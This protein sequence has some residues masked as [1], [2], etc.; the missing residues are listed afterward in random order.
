M[1]KE[2]LPS[3]ECFTTEIETWKVKWQE[4]STNYG[5]ASLP[6][7]PRGTLPQTSEMYPSIKVLLTI[8]ATLPV[9]TCSA[10]RSFSSLKRTKTS[11]RSSMTT[12]RLTD[13]PDRL[14]HVF[15]DIEVDLPSA[16][17]EFAC[18]H[19]RRLQMSDVLSD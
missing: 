17:D 16:I 7:S 11:I 5:N 10:E 8:L 3:P 2:D 14:L 9:T 19:P 4:H 13:K 6:D 1:Y 12:T 15:R 18:R